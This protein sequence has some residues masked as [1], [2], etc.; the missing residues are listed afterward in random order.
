MLAT[1]T[2]L[3]MV[4][5]ARALALLAVIGSFVLALFA[6]IDPTWLKFAV[7]VGFDV[8]VLVPLVGLYWQK[9]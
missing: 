6:V 7:A 2:A 1:M 5:S 4:L 3:A 8:F 9:G